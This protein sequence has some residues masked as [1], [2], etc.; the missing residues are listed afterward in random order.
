MAVL[1]LLVN[2]FQSFQRQKMFFECEKQLRN[3]SP[4]EGI[5]SKSGASLVRIFATRKCTEANALLSSRACL[6]LRDTDDIRMMT[7][8]IQDAGLGS[9]VSLPRDTL[10]VCACALAE[11]ES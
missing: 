7:T 6:S 10:I 1:F 11:R 3:T 8:V 4:S 9:F 5:E 2:Y